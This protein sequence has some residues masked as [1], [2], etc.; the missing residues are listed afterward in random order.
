MALPQAVYEH[1]RYGNGARPG[2]SAKLSDGS[3]IVVTR[4]TTVTRN[5]CTGASSYRS[6]IEA[7][8][9]PGDFRTN[10]DAKGYVISLGDCPGNVEWFTYWT[11]EA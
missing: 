3:E 8:Q 11:H 4:E 7:V 9:Y 6:R 10:P 5:Y 2:A 1:L